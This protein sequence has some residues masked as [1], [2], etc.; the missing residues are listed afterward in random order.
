MVSPPLAGHM[1]VLT[2]SLVH[3]RVDITN[4]QQGRCAITLLRVSHPPTWL[5]CL[6]PTEVHSSKD[7]PTD[8]VNL[9]GGNAVKASGNAVKSHPY[10]DSRLGPDTVT[11]RIMKFNCMVTVHFMDEAASHPRL[12][13]PF[14][15]LIPDL[16]TLCGDDAFYECSELASIVIPDSV[17]EVR[18][19]APSSTDAS[20][21]C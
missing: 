21:W 7:Q 11:S 17:P 4:C 18:S 2:D 20:T 9:I 3:G 1:P 6:H 5:R 12:P 16:V 13:L 8:S 10:R 15:L 19:L 14:L